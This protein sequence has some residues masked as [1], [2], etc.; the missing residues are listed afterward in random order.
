MWYPSLQARSTRLGGPNGMVFPP[1]MGVDQV[2][3]LTTV[4][5]WNTGLNLKDQKWTQWASSR[6]E[7]LSKP[8]ACVCHAG[9]DANWGLG[10]DSLKISATCLCVTARADLKVNSFVKYTERCFT[11]LAL[12]KGPDVRALSRL[13]TA[14]V[15]RK[16]TMLSKRLPTLRKVLNTLAPFTA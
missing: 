15:P 10:G 12:S 9:L 8:A 14:P 1:P 6:A 13:F 2:W 11:L 3:S 16:E 7:D 5:A 4:S